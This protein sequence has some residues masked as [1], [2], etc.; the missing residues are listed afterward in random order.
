MLAQKKMLIGVNEKDFLE[1]VEEK[2]FALDTHEQTRAIQLIKQ[3]VHSLPALSIPNKGKRILQ[4]DA[5]DLYWAAVLLE[6]NNGKRNICG[7]KSGSFSDAEKHYHSTFKEIL[8]V[9]RGIEKF[10]FHLI[11]HHFFVEMDMSAF[12]KMLSFK[13]KQIPNS[14]LLRWAEWFANFDFEVK[15]IKGHNNLLP[16]LLSRPKPKIS[17]IK[18]I[19][20]ICMMG[21]SSSKPSSSKS[22]SS[23][24]SEIYPNMD[25]FSPEINN[26]IKDKT[27]KAR[28]RELVL[29]YQSLV[30]QKHGIHIFG[31]LGF[32]PDYPFLNLFFFNPDRLQWAFSKEILCFLWYLLELHKIPFCFNAEAMA[33]WLPELGHDLWK[34][35][36][37][38]YPEPNSYAKK[39]FEWFHPVNHWMEKFHVYMGKFKDIRT[40]VKNVHVIIVFDRQGYFTET[41]YCTHFSHTKDYTVLPYNLRKD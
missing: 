9:K 33:T 2:C 15:H 11:G 7:Y 10:Q 31:G 25:N 28:S 38:L 3:K 4:T 19:P 24:P 26:L 30:I 27:L 32:H 17:A 12:P 20:I 29:K 5:S 21:P 1:Y 23:R 39:F 35:Y 34:T 6:E 13:Q 22:F 36:P 8:A 18:P 37:E 14:Q 16:D 40:S 41:G